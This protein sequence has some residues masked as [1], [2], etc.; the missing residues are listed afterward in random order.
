MLFYFDTADRK[1]R[2]GF[3]RI[4]A[5]PDHAPYGLFCVAAGHQ[6]GFND[7]KAIEVAGYVNAIAGKG[8]EPFSFR[9]GLRIQTLVETIQTSSREQRW[10]DVQ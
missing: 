4:E 2:Q 6:L 1:G 9:K 10:L 5:G 7:L 8:P 3:R